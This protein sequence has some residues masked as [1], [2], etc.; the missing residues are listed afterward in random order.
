MAMSQG[1]G[2][3]ASIVA[4]MPGREEITAKDLWRPTRHIAYAKFMDE[5]DRRG[6]TF[7]NLKPLWRNGGL[8]PPNC[9]ITCFS[10]LSC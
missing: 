7:T 3:P 5:L 10:Q 1:V 6:S 9:S 2:Y 4:H 8:G